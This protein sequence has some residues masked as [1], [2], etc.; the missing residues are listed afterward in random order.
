MDLGLGGRVAL[1]TGASKGLG[2]AVAEVF[3]EEGASVA[4]NA[5]NV[6]A[7]ATTAQEIQESSG[8]KVVAIP[9]DLT[10]PGSCERV[11]EETVSEFGRLDVLFTN[12]GGPPPGGVDDFDAEAYEAALQLNLMSAVRLTLGAIP[13]MREQGWGRIVAITSVSVKQPVPGLL[14][15][16]MARPG[17]VGF[18]KSISQEL[19]KENILCNVAA[20]GYIETERV[21]NLLAAKAEASGSDVAA[22]RAGITSAI[23]MGRIGRPRE[24]ANG[25]AF[26]ASEAASYVSG[27]TFQI[28]GGYIQGLL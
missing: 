17:V 5:R 28:D 13:H 27:H 6:E 7:L 2:R 19:A 14:L 23:P 22:V 10:E 26:L 25:V 9:G 8:Q 3:A 16:N 18:I 21:E 12:A 11:I 15:S 1:V 24:F 20:P 4:V